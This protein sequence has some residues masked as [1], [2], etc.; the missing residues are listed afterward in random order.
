MSPNVPRFFLK[1]KTQYSERVFGMVSDYLIFCYYKLLASKIVYSKK[2][3]SEHTSI[4]FENYL[5][6]RFLYEYIQK[7]KNE[8]KTFNPDYY[9]VIA[10][11]LYFPEVQ[12][13]FKKDSKLKASKIDIFVTNLNK[14]LLGK[15]VLEQIYYDFECK[16]LNN[17]LI[18]EYVTHGIKRHLERD[19]ENGF[20]FT[21]MIGFVEDGSIDQIVNDINKILKKQKKS[22]FSNIEYLGYVK[23]NNNFKNSYKSKHLK[24]NS[25]EFCIYHLLFDY[26]N[27][28][29]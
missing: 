20:S 25:S 26:S 28:L 6:D 15:D 12:T 18:K 1:R 22:T 2:N 9:K 11:F 27:I 14:N 21:G 17:K 10:S 16:R 5:R 23:L 24:C 3:I 13:L 4:S 19:Y 29:S 7:F 8:Y